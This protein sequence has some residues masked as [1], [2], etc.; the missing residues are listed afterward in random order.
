VL[1]NQILVP[2]IWTAL[3]VFLSVLPSEDIKDIDL[4]YF[5]KVGHFF[6]YASWSFL[7]IFSLTKDYFS[8]SRKLKIYLGT[9]IAAIMIGILL[10]F[11]QKYFTEDRNFDFL[12]IVSNLLGALFGIIIFL[13][14]KINRI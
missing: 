2:I 1:P 6:L 14:L 13:S 11:V 4:P 8:K 10:E 5:D 12:D 3:I 9:F 7:I